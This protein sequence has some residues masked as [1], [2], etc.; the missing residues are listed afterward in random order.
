MMLKKIGVTGTRRGLV[1]AQRAALLGL[2]QAFGG[3][4]QLHHGDDMGVDAEAD[5][6]ARALG[7]R[8]VTHPP[9]LSGHRAYRASA[10][11]RQPR[12]F[13]ERNRDI[14]AEVGGLLAC[15]GMMVEEQRSGT[16]ATVRYARERGVPVVIVW[17]DGS[18]S[19]ERC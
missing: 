17:P 6:L 4:C 12:P 5:V 11:P 15:P 3:A 19:R 1:A 16:W 18:V 10:E 7:W 13:L 8:V 9:L 14:V 2:M